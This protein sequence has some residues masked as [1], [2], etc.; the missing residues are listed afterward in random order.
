M[1]QT[2]ST[3]YAQPGVYAKDGSFRVTVNV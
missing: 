2:P 1:T 3:N